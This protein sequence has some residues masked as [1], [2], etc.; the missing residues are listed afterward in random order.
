MATLPEHI[1]ELSEFF[2]FKVGKRLLVKWIVYLTSQELPCA[3]VDREGRSKV[4][5]AKRVEIII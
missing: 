5:V 4:S 1:S 2:G 3:P